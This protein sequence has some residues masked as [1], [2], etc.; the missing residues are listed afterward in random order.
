[1]EERREVTEISAVLLVFLAQKRLQPHTTRENRNS[2]VEYTNAVI[3]AGCHPG[4]VTVSRDG[5]L[6][7]FTGCGEALHN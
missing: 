2:A 7:V 1:M 4:N 6:Q 5:V 3:C